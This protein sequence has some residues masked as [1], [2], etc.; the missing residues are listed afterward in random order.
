MIATDLDPYD[1]DNLESIGC[2]LQALAAGQRRIEAS[3]RIPHDSNYT[4]A[5]LAEIC[6][7][8][9]AIA[10]NVAE[11][12]AQLAALSG[13][14]VSSMSRFLPSVRIDSCSE[15]SQ[16]DSH[17]EPCEEDSSP[18]LAPSANWTEGLRCV[19]EVAIQC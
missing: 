8:Q 9:Q 14:G 3:L 6:R 16:E 18:S 2:Q 19:L 1:V 5:P 10:T 17:L 11:I 12:Q 15:R 13:R 7:T 4:I